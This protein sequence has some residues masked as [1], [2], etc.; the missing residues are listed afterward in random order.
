MSATDP[1]SALERA[2]RTAWDEADG[3]VCLLYAI[4]KR[5][6]NP[7]NFVLTNVQRLERIALLLTPELNP[8]TNRHSGLA[9]SEVGYVTTYFATAAQGGA[10]IDAVRRGT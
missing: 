6:E 1:Q 4:G 3:V 8:V 9:S 10:A 7:S 5:I 2:S